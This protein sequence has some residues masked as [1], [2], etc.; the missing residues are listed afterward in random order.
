MFT[1]SRPTPGRRAPGSARSSRAGTPGRASPAP[2]A[3]AGAAAAAG[4]TP[5]RLRGAPQSRLYEPDTSLAN[6]ADMTEGSIAGGGSLEEGTILL[7]DD[8]TAV[9][10]FT[11]LPLEV[12]QLLEGSGEC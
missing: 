3:K 12:A 6:D 7:K 9:T 8:I 5:S 2:F 4:Y 10:A 1:P 11:R